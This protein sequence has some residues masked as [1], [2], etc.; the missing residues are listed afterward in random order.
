MRGDCLPRPDPV[1]ATDGRIALTRRAP[2]APPTTTPDA[3]ALR[4]PDSSHPA[5]A[6]GGGERYP[7]AVRDVADGVL[8]GGCELWP[9]GTGVCN[10][11]YWTYPAHRRA[12]FASRSVARLCAVAFEVGGFER[13]EIVTD[14]DN[15]ASR[16]VALRNGF[17]EVGWRDG[18]VL[19]VL[20]KSAGSRGGRRGGVSADPHRAR[21]DARAIGREWHVLDIR[22][23]IVGG[24]VVAGLSALAVHGL[25]QLPDPESATGARG[26]GLCVPSSS[27]AV[28]ANVLARSAAVARGTAMRLAVAGATV[29][30]A[31]GVTSAR[32][33]RVERAHYGSM[34][35]L[36]GTPCTFSV[37]EWDA[38]GRLYY[39]SDCV[40]RTS[41]GGIVWGAEGDV[42]P[43]SR[44]RVWMFD[45]ATGRAP[46][47]VA[48]SPQ[49]LVRQP[50]HM[51]NRQLVHAAGLQGRSGLEPQPI[52]GSDPGLRSPDGRWT[53]RVVTQFYEPEHVVLVRLR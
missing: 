24:V 39:Q 23:A 7:F 34:E 42:S 30:L 8:V 45:P 41:V 52:L 4:P 6:G 9:R 38:A 51:A 47:S 25:Y 36:D 37:L 17:E 19:H 2:C 43:D 16:R 11:S 48:A 21:G 26:V 10:V 44:R 22:R 27:V 14:P 5:A 46:Q 3:P 15:I 20:D 33:G 50:S 29:A 18:Q 32:D 53:A 31:L 1:P 12:G 40:T 35:R 28:V 49:S 13:L